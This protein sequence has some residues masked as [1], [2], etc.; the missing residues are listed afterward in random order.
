M[1]L[2]VYKKFMQRFISAEEASEALLLKCF[3]FTL[4]KSI[5][6]LINKHQQS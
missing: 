3:Y 2:S 1:S 5:W 6:P 4:K